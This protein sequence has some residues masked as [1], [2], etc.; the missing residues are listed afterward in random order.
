M[1]K[2]WKRALS[3]A[4]AVVMAM[5][6]ITIDGTKEVKAADEARAVAFEYQGMHGSLGWKFSHTSLPAA[7]QGKDDW[8]S[9]VCY[10][11]EVYKDGNSKAEK[12]WLEFVGST[13]YIYGELHYEDKMVPTTSLYI[14]EGTIMYEC[15]YDSGSHKINR[16]TDGK[17][18]KLSEEFKMVCKEGVWSQN[19]IEGVTVT[20]R[21]FD[22]SGNWLFNHSTLPDEFQGKDNWSATVRYQ[23]KA[24]VDDSTELQTGWLEMVGSTMYIYPGAFP[25]GKA[26]TSKFNIPMGSVL[27]QYDPDS[28]EVVPEG[29]RIRM[30]AA[31]IMTKDANGNWKQQ[32]A[33]DSEYD[34]IND[35]VTDYRIVLPAEPTANEQYAADELQYFIEEATGVRIVLYREGTGELPKKFISVG[36]TKVSR[37]AGVTPTYEELKTNGFVIKTIEDDCYIKGYGDMGTRNGAYEFLSYCFDYECYAPDSI[38]LTKTKSRKLP[39]F[40]VTK[41]PDFEF[42]EASSETALDAQGAYRMQYNTSE[43]IFVTGHSCHNTYTIIDPE[44]DYLYT[45]AKYKDWYSTATTTH[46]QRG[47]RVLPAQLCFSNEEVKAEF[48]KNLKAFLAA[49][50][51]GQPSMMIGME[52]N[53]LWC[54]CSACSASKTKYGTNAATMIKFINFLQEEIN[55]WYATEYPDEVPVQ[56]VMFA[57]HQSEEPPVTWDSESGN[58]VPIDE[59]VRLHEDVG[60]MYAPVRAS[61]AYDF[62]DKIN[63][64]FKAQVEGWDALTSDLYMWTYGIYTQNMFL[65]MDTFHILEANY[66]FFKNCGARFMF[67]MIGGYNQNGNSGWERAR[68]YVMSRLMWDIDQDIDMLL[69]EFFAYYFGDAADIMRNLMNYNSQYIKDNVWTKLEYIPPTDDNYGTVQ[70]NVFVQI[71]ALHSSD[72]YFTTTYLN[73][74]L[75]RI[76]EAYAA[77]EKYKFTDPDKYW[78]LHEHINMESLQ[79]RYILIRWHK[80]PNTY[81][82]TQYE[83]R[84]EFRRDYENLGIIGATDFWTGLNLFGDLWGMPTEGEGTERKLVYNSVEVTYADVDASGNLYLQGEIVSGPNK[85]KTLAGYYGNASIGSGKISY[86][87]NGKTITEENTWKITNADASHGNS[88]ICVQATSHLSSNIADV[89]SVM[90]KKGEIIVVGNKTPFQIVNDVNVAKADGTWT[91]YNDV[92]LTYTKTASNGQIHFNAQFV[93]GPDYKQITDEY[94]DSHWQTI[95]EVYGDWAV[96]AVGNV[97]YTIDGVDKGEQTTYFDL[98]NDNMGDYNANMLMSNDDFIVAVRSGKAA[99][100]TIKEGTILAVEGNRALRVA[101]DVTM[102]KNEGEDWDIDYNVVK[103]SYDSFVPDTDRNRVGFYLNAE[104][105]SGPDAGRLVHKVYGSWANPPAIGAM[106]VTAGSNSDTKA[107]LYSVCE[108]NGAPQIYISGN[109]AYDDLALVTFTK[110]TVIVPTRL[111]ATRTPMI[112]ANNLKI[113]A[114]ED[115]FTDEN[116]VELIYHS[117]DGQRGYY[118]QA[119]ITSGPDAG[120]NMAD[121]YG[122]WKNSPAVKATVYRNGEATEQN[123][124]WSPCTQLVDDTTEYDRVYISGDY[125]EYMKEVTEIK[126]SKDTL[127]VPNNTDYSGN[128]LR[129][130]KEVRIVNRQKAEADNENNTFFDPAMLDIKVQDTYEDEDAGATAYDMRFIASVD[131][132]EYKKAGFVFSLANDNPTKDGERCA[133]REVGKVYNTIRGGINNVRVRADQLYEGNSQYLY[134]FEITGVPAETVIYVRAY[135]EL[136]DGTIVYGTTRAVAAPEAKPAA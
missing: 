5:G 65:F 127:I 2:I 71:P 6:V 28:G 119:E 56:L 70:G 126:L 25:G 111:E 72:T 102:T 91:E 13:A 61:Y 120:A 68:N 14:P 7:Y 122:D 51:N 135:V 86:D 63:A 110:G 59:S 9:T 18:L 123:V 113:A 132:L 19:K 21:E 30:K 41:V 55:E 128:P 35:G 107:V 87:E 23:F 96:R 125:A 16:V 84:W 29:K 131:V 12:I 79:F 60:V 112:L 109:Y 62:T 124:V 116:Q 130:T 58:Y 37:D 74:A 81:Y 97:T 57:Y 115:G 88:T 24:Y 39:M 99:E 22:G 34:F 48:L 36:N 89:T 134:A 133:S 32:E 73:E 104:I 117:F 8:S 31:C 114:T 45:D 52:D 64:R 53:N 38:Q 105:I 66:S 10:E 47:Q 78:D 20:F 77:I 44:G 108:N 82:K 94:G 90:L 80:D 85:G 98:Y 121:V 103:I 15:T 40:D 92:E 50:R 4:L 27:E 43:E 129:L 17:Q 11:V 83:Y 49:N 33:P 100:F 1:K 26:P 75:S 106:T 42:R 67:D 46:N 118:L 54:T 76:D 136:Y 93:S 3:L 69:D 101:S 95:G